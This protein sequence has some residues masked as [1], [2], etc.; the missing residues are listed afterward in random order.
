MP[1]AQKLLSYSSMRLIFLLVLMMWVIT[2]SVAQPLRKVD[3]V[4]VYPSPAISWRVTGKDSLV[5][6]VP[7]PQYKAGPVKRLLAGSHYRKAWMTPIWVPVLDPH[8]EHGGLTY[9]KRGGNKQTL[10]VNVKDTNE[11]IFTIRSIQKNP[12]KALPMHMRNTLISNVARDQVSSMHPTAFLII[13]ELAD[14]LRIRHTN[15]KIFYVTSDTLFRDAQALF[16]GRFVMLEEKF[17]GKFTLPGFKGPVVSFKTE[18]AIDTMRKDPSIR[19]DQRTVLRARLLDMIIGDWDRSEDQWK[20]LLKEGDGKK[21]LVPV[22]R[23]RDQAMVLMDGVIPWFYSQEFMSRKYQGFRKKVHDIIGLNWNARTFDRMFLN[24]LTKEDWL[25]EA[26]SVKAL[27]TDEVISKALNRMPA[28][29]VATDGALI[30]LK[31]KR[32]RD[33]LGKIAASYYKL[34]S[35]DVIIQGSSNNDLFTIERFKG[36]SLKVEM[37]IQNDLREPVYSRVIKADDTEEIQI[38]GNEGND[39]ISL[40]GESDK[41][42][43]V[44]FIGGAGVDTVFDRSLVKGAGKNTRVYDLIGDVVID[45][46]K[47]TKDLTSFDIRVNENSAKEYTYDSYMPKLIFSYNIDQGIL[48]GAGFSYTHEEF[49]KKPYAFYQEVNYAQS[50]R[51]NAFYLTT[52]TDF[53]NMF[54]K[55]GLK[56]NTFIFPSF[57]TSFYGLG[58]ETIFRDL[59]FDYYRVRM[60]RTYVSPMLYRGI[61]DRVT[62]SL[63]AEYSRHTA[64]PDNNRFIR[65]LLR[66]RTLHQQFGSLKAEY[67]FRNADYFDRDAGFQWKNFAQWKFAITENADNFSRLGSEASGFWRINTFLRPVLAMRVGGMMN[68]GAFPFYESAFVGGYNFERENETLRGF[69]RN[70]FAGRS[71]AYNNNELRVR[72]V[73]FGFSGEAGVFGF[74]DVGRVWID[75]DR[76]DIWHTG[77]GGGIWV[78]PTRKFVFTVTSAHSRE[79]SLVNVDMGFFF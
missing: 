4:S 75:N 43:V 14:A 68:F 47:E 18:E 71:C 74:Y 9:V 46:S 15:P 72:L 24:E 66:G 70:R 45:P 44:R 41:K 5:M 27:L 3:S 26:D 56:L 61:N 63:G 58:N 55:W 33:A 67:I 6:I 62:L 40:K 20:W 37:F 32:R 30:G 39:K 8:R 60:N 77:T 19:V 79:E 52:V 64:F 34:V 73:T 29:H 57:V 1:T 76:S 22:P 35:E 10:V 69:R 65:P 13:P 12:V 17:E 54:G 21:I 7:G 2:T 16:D 36:D 38:Y 49:R 51:N 23:D 11:Q 31:L 59:N 28:E 78:K 25:S 48:A 53:S 50:L 42:I